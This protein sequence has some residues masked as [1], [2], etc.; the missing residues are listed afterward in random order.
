MSQ[1]AIRAVTCQSLYSSVLNQRFVEKFLTTYQRT[2]FERSQIIELTAKILKAMVSI[3]HHNIF[4]VEILHT[5][6]DV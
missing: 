3:V 6:P 2:F 5:D 1:S 4:V